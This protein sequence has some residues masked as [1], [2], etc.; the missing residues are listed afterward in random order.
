MNVWHSW[1]ANLVQGRALLCSYSLKIEWAIPENIQTG[2]RGGG[3]VEGMEF[4]GVL[5]KKRGN[6]RGQFKK[7][8]KFQWYSRKTNVEFPW[9]WVLVFYFGIAKGCHTNLQNFQGKKLFFSGISWGKVTY[10][11][12]SGGFSEEYLYPQP[13]PQL[14]FFWKSQISCYLTVLSTYKSRHNQ[15]IISVEI[16]INSFYCY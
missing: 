14:D 4:P 1:Q 9:P 8:W 5:K 2:G 13:H 10:L 12:F 6:S 11:K 16:T 7:K 15:K 3:G